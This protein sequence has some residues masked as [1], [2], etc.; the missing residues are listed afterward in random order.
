M[1]CNDCQY[2]AVV[3]DSSVNKKKTVVVNG[4]TYYCKANPVGVK[5]DDKNPGRVPDKVRLPSW[6]P[7]AGYYCQ[8]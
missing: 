4:M 1:I 2:F 3:Y 5:I 7:L 8:K 6:C